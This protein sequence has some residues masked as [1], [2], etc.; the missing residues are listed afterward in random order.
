M[1]KRGQDRNPVMGNTVIIILI[2]ILLIVA[3][4]VFGKHVLSLIQ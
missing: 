4:I 3:T 2:V 1:K